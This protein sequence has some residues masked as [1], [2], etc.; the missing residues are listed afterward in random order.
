MKVEL[1]WAK[2][3]C[4]LHLTV[5]CLWKETKGLKE[6]EQG[7]QERQLTGETRAWRKE[8]LGIKTEEQG[9][10]LRRFPKGITQ[11]LKR[12][13]GNIHEKDRQT[14]KIWQGPNPL[15][16]LSYSCEQVHPSHIATCQSRSGTSEPCHMLQK[17]KKKR[18][19]L[20]NLHA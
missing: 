13:W 19:D 9:E 12:Y 2:S 6:E 11:F 17:K 8:K 18:H 7:A 1:G 3:L 14:E 5:F 10:I 15:R 16:I 20:L 4:Q